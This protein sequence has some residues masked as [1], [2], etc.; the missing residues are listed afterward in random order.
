MV[1][2]INF[3]NVLVINLGNIE[4]FMPQTAFC[5]CPV[6]LTTVANWFVN[7][8]ERMLPVT[9]ETFSPPCRLR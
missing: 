1:S 7:I 2:R 5:P 3:I 9:A 8:S 6:K 4:S